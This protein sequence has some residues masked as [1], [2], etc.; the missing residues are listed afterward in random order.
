MPG[1][2]SRIKPQDL[3]RFRKFELLARQ[4]VEGLVTGLH[5]SPYK[6]FAIEFAEHRQYVPGDDVKR[7]DWKLFGRFSRYFIREYEEDTSLKAFFVLD[8]SG[9]MSYTSHGMSKLEFGQMLCMTL[10]YLLL[11]QNDAVGC[12]TCDS[13]INRYLPAYSTIN[14]LQRIGHL[15]EHITPENDTAL[16]NVLHSLANMIKRR[17]LIFIISDFFDNLTEIMRAFNHFARRH[18]ELVLLQVIDPAERDFPFWNITRFES[19]EHPSERYLID[20]VRI[21]NDY[22]KHFADHQQQL[23]R[24]AHELHY[25]FQTFTTERDAAEQLVPYLIRRMRR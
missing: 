5:K 14:Q 1:V 23:K 3:Q 25:D 12:I 6:G 9:S 20:P 22:L 4:V 17:S 8:T 24:L 2:F 7:L 21:R 11:R 19:M 16:A 10:S 13:K 15:L 18:H